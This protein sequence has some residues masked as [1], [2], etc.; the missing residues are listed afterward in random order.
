M[1]TYTTND[2]RYAEFMGEIREFGRNAAMGRDSPP[3]V[4]HAFVR[5]IVDGVLDPAK[6]SNGDDA[7]ARVFQEDAKAKGEKSVHDRSEESLKANVS[8]LR[9]LQKAAEQSKFDLVDVMNRAFTIRDRLV[10]QKV[11]VKPR[12]QPTLTLLASSQAGYR[13]DRRPDRSR[14]YSVD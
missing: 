6:D 12:M 4:A 7:A 2:T 9:Q 1:R 14:G 11:E 13:L 8:K 10:D 5:A 3:M